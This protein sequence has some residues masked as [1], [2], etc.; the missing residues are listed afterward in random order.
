MIQREGPGWRLAFDHS[1]QRFPYL[2]G[3]TS[4]AVELTE[5]EAKGLYDLLGELDKQYLLIR[6][7]LLDEESIT[8]ELDQQPWWGCLDG[9]SDHWGLQVV[10][11]GNGLE[12]R[13]LE[14][15]WP[16]PA[17]EAFWAA[18]RTVWD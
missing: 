15:A 3:G 8:L 16:A 7:Q 13:G 11:Q 10:L 14:G 12:G 18:L 4:W 2:I 9:T 5:L 17:A 1:R 6:D